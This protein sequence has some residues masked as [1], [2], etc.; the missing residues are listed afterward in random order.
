MC[1]D[2]HSLIQNTECLL[3]LGHILFADGTFPYGPCDSGQPLFVV[4]VVEEGGQ[5][6]KSSM[7]PHQV[8]GFLVFRTLHRKPSQ[9]LS[10]SGFIKLS[11]TDK[12]A[13]NLV[14]TKL[15]FTECHFLKEPSSKT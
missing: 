7:Q 13:A 15:L 10:W 2:G 3:L 11:V 1:F 6:F 8:A 5:G 14:A 12:E 9:T 4:S